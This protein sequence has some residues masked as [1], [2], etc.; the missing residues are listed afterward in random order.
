MIRPGAQAGCLVL[1]GIKAVAEEYREIGF[2]IF[3]PGK[4]ISDLSL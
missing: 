1:R 3:D 4:F 2:R